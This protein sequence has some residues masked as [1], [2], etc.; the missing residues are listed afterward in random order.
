MRCCACNKLLSDFEAT[1]KDAK[2]GE[3]VDMCNTCLSFMP[4]EKSYKTRPDLLKQS[5]D[6][7]DEQ[8]V[9]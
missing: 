1:R 8:E 2:T 5:T 9:F 7:F 4:P 6:E 3:Y